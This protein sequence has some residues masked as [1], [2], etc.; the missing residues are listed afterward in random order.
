MH[1]YYWGIIII[2]IIVGL[3][4]IQKFYANGYI[5]INKGPCPY[6]MSFS[7]VHYHLSPTKYELD[8]TIIHLL[9]CASFV[10]NIPVK[11]IFTEIV[12]YLQLVIQLKKKHK[13][14]RYLYSVYGWK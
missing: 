7:G 9:K 10:Q 1:F 3:F 5:G 11:C 14:F 13:F 12:R 2:F 4:L 8:I 6:C